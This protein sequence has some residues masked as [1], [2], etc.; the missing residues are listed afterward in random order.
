MVL[1]KFKQLSGLDTNRSG[2]QAASVVVLP[3][4]AAT[5]DEVVDLALQ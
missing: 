2:L 3:Q 4:L 5:F 1:R